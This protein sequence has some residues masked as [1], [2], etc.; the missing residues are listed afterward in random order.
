MATLLAYIT[1]QAGGE[2]PTF[3]VMSPGDYA[4][5]N[6]DFIG[7]ENIYVNPGSTYTMDTAVRSTFPNLNVSGIPIFSDHFVPK[8]SVFFVNVKYTSDVLV[9]GRRLRLQRVLLAGAIGA[10]RPAGRRGRRLR[11]GYGE[12]S[13]KCL[14]L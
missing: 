11:R 4:T 14:V 13:G 8:G 9:G 12:I 10:D 3:V 1:D 2:A 6:N 5:L 7:T